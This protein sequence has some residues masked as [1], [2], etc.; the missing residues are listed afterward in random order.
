MIDIKKETNYG[1][2]KYTTN[3]ITSGPIIYSEE[4]A[5]QF[6][7]EIIKGKGTELYQPRNPEFNHTQLDK[8]KEEPEIPLKNNDELIEKSKSPE[9][10]IQQPELKKLPSTKKKKKGKLEW[11]SVPYLNSH[12]K[13]VQISD[14]LKFLFAKFNDI[15]KIYSKVIHNLLAYL[16]SKIYHYKIVRF[17]ILYL[18]NS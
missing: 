2:T 14:V 4:N 11:N 16:R 18:K 13:I 8:I 3:I 7:T 6:V 9:E 5:K 1:N 15:N 17:L 12:F 10:I